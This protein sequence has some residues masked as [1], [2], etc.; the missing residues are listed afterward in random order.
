MGAMHD[1]LLNSPIIRLFVII[2]LGYLVGE[3]KFPGGF[4]L[5]VAGVLFVGLACGVW[6]PTMELPDEFQTLGLVLFVY[7]VGL[8]AA[9]GFFKS[10]RRDGL[11]LNLSVLAGLTLAF[12]CAY[13]AIR[14]SGRPSSLI[15]GV[16]CGALTN[17]PALGAVT[18]AI[19]NGGGTPADVN[20]AVVGY[21]VAYPIAIVLVLLLAQALSVGVRSTEPGDAAEFPIRTALTI[22][23]ETAAENG[24]AWSAELVEQRTGVVLSR[25]RTP[26]GPIEI[27]TDA[28][29]L[30]TGSLVVAVGNAD[31]L[32]SAI[33]LLGRVSPVSLQQELHGF[34][35]LRYFVSKPQAIEKPVGELG[36]EK[37]G[38]VVTRLRRGDVDLPVTHETRLQLGDRVQVISY[39]DMERAVRDF[40]GNSL[41]ALTETGYFSF[42]VGIILGLILGQIPF[43]VPGLSQPVRLGVAGGPLVVALILGSIGR[44]GPFIWIL[45]GEINL[46]LRHLGILFFLA[47][48]GVKAGHGLFTHLQ[49]DGWIILAVSIAVIVVAHLTLLLCLRCFNQRKLSVLLGVVSGLQTQ[50][51]VLTFA[52][53]K[54]PTGP[55]N[56][57]YAAAYPLAV[58]LKII[59]AQVLVALG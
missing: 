45:P 49:T 34:D 29:A 31:Q 39:K 37:L 1:W 13:A 18:E 40:F 44:T 7:C 36:L 22:A 23:V 17:T 54:A 27:V 51:A 46:T 24:Q 59:L 10:F 6:S 8:Q 14:W 25:R 43:P 21:G 57:A 50:P 48:V 58:I 5:G 38:A 30:P 15:T 53:T 19:A 52:A 12:L 28:A 4:R 47:A 11:A 20:L 26:G 42:A 3:I 9:P 32:K 55:L 16:F 35:V 41:T 2:A 56:T 33:A